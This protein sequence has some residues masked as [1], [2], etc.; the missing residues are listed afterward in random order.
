ML[1]M[2]ETQSSNSDIYQILLA[3]RSSMDLCKARVQDEL[4]KLRLYSCYSFVLNVPLLSVVDLY[5]MRC[6]H[7]N[8]Y[9]RKCMYHV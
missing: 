9:I 4:G 5:A 1:F 6:H 2:N 7:V 3:L 8:S